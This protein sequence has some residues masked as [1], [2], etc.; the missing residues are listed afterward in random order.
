[1]TSK[2]GY[3]VLDVTGFRGLPSKIEINQKK[4]LLRYSS[5]STEILKCE[6]ISFH[7]QKSKL[8]VNFQRTIRTH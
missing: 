1:M 2:T 3:I 6:I 8:K 7:L 5:V 4:E